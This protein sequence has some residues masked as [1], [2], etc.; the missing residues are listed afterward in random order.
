MRYNELPGTPSP[1]KLDAGEGL[2]FAFGR[3]LATVI[4]RPEDLGVSMAGTI[5]SGGKGA[6]FPLHRHADTYEALYVMEGSISL[7]LGDKVFHLLPGDYVNIPPGTAHGFTYLDHRSKL[8]AW[9]FGG[10]ANTIYA[11]IGQSYEGTVY[12]ESIANIDWGKPVAGIDVE[13]LDH[14]TAGASP[15]AAKLD[16][17][18]EEVAPF[19]LGESEGERLI[20]GE[21]VYTLMGGA[22]NS[23]G[24][25]H[26]V[27][28]EGPKGPMIPK[29]MHEKVCETFFCL[30]G[31]L[32]MLVGDET[33][34]LA[35][36]DFVYV[37]AGTPH[38]YQIVKNDT[39]FLGFL[40]P[41]YFEQFFRYLAQPFEGYIYP[42]VPPP[43]RFDRVIQHLGELDL[44]L[45]GR[46]GGPTPPA[47]A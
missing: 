17:A 8:V 14:A 6:H 26:S 40:T 36:G 21:Q 3:H 46:P 43:F 29:H 28:A 10:N 35:P 2:R 25:F 1:F 42:L 5:L 15:S 12:S 16:L 33:V 13:F 11:A 41:G 18:P 39:R 23:N 31:G 27:M 47:G 4:A 9:T 37:P 7:T 24:L 38:A 22:Q 30:N 44:K 45:L 19:V 34:T 32:V 20:A